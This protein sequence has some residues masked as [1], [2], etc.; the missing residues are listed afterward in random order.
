MPINDVAKLSASELRRL[1]GTH[2]ISPTEVVQACLTQI[3][4]HNESINAAVTLNDHALE[5]ARAL[6]NRSRSREKGLLY[7]LPIGIKD[8]TPVAGLRTTYG[9]P[10]FANNIA[11]E[12]ALIVERLKSADAIVLCK[13]N[14][15][16]FAAGANTFNEVFGRTR[17]PW[18]TRLSAGGS[19]GGSAAALASGMVALAEGTDL[20]GSLRIPASF[21]GVVGLRS[22]PG[23]VPTY[24]SGFLWDTLQIEGGMGRTVADVA[25]MLQATAG[26]SKMA[27]LGQPA[28]TR[29]FVGSLERGISRT[30]RIAYCSDISNIGVD[31]E[32]DQSCRE[33]ALGLQSDVKQV[34]EIDLDLSSYKDT[35]HTLRGYW[36]VAHHRHRLHL[37]DKF[38][39]NLAGNI[40]SGLQLTPEQ[41]GR[42]E[43]SR[44][45]LWLFFREFFQSYDYLLTPC[46]AVRPFQVEQNYPLEIAGQPMETYI[47]WFAP[48][49]LIS[50]TGL[51]V[52][53]V[54]CGLDS[55]GLPIG[56]QIIG[57]PHD[58]ES[59]LALADHVQRS[60][61]IGLPELKM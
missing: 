25:L 5:E 50:L 18:D 48:T 21:C 19:S 53:S 49:Y 32:V 8:I 24:P 22:S 46:V 10:L 57:R 3:E 61:P 29:D 28:S 13:T 33:T 34:E 54:P 60:C 39:E 6:E 1:L 23:L 51:P 7:G 31:V 14:T 41:L 38:G 45:K 27:P 35:F 44:G 58:E 36:M 59:V 47:D 2:E 26:S 4:R 9:S 16:E 30:A 37:K 17:N 43:Q 56:L 52:A 11:S 42:A 40:N 55:S 15:P 20:G 12:D